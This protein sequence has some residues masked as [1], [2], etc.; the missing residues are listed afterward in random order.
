M[1]TEAA[2]CRGVYTLGKLSSSGGKATAN[3]SLSNS[4]QLF[5]GQSLNDEGDTKGNDGKI[6]GLDEIRDLQS[7]LMLIGGKQRKEK[8]SGQIQKDCFIRV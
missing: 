2:N 4:L 1:E 6:Y 5:V 7:K 3:S 8:D